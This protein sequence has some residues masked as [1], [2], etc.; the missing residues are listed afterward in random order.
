MD[1]AVLNEMQARGKEALKILDVG[2]GSGCIAIALAGKYPAAK[3]FASDISKQSLEIAKHN[4]LHNKIV[5]DFIEDDILSA[6][7]DLFPNTSLDFVVSNPPYVLESEKTEMAANVLEHEPAEALFV[8]D[9][10]PLLFYRS[11]ASKA[12]RWLKSYGYLFFEINEKFA[13]ECHDMILSAGFSEIVIRK[14]IH[15]KDRFIRARR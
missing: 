11:I 7:S 10:D 13:G 1:V 15:G 6:C 9:D 12:H 14:D 4:A 8:P 2:T 5:V 3:V